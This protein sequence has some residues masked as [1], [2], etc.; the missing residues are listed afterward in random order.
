MIIFQDAFFLAGMATI[1]F[2]VGLICACRYVAWRDDPWRSY[3]KRSH[4]RRRWGG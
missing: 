2:A 4:M 1:I 3:Q